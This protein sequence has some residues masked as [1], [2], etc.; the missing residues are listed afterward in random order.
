MGLFRRKDKKKEVPSL[1]ELPKLPDFPRLE[2]KESLGS[3]EFIHQLP[4]FPSNSL[5]KKFSQDSIKDA[6]TGKKDGVEGSEVD[7]FGMME[8]MRRIRGPLI[9]P[10][11]E[12]LTED[13]DR[14]GDI[15]TERDVGVSKVMKRGV[16]PVFIRIDR[17]EEGLHIFEETK[18]KISEIERALGETKRIKEKEDRELQEWEN[19]IRTIKDQIEKIDRDIFS[20]I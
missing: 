11:T 14:E 10:L 9:K 3:N 13:I 18:K 15:F 6:V 19:E 2:D 20:K 1:P 12:E 7:E 5:G 16:E 4:G 8:D 17:F